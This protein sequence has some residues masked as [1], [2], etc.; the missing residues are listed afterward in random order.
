MLLHL[1]F[2]EDEEAAISTPRIDVYNMG[3][4][5]CKNDKLVW[6]WLWLCIA[7][8]DEQTDQLLFDIIIVKRCSEYISILFAVEQYAT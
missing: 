5:Y 6:E 7:I 3:H 1:C 4:I 8:A 2:W